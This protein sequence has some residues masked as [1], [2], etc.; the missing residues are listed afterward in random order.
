MK[1]KTTLIEMIGEIDEGFIS[2]YNT[3]RSERKKQKRKN[4]IR[5]A[6]SIAAGAVAMAAIAVAIPFFMK[7]DGNLPPVVTADSTDTSVTDTTSP[8]I[9]PK[10]GERYKNY[11]GTDQGKS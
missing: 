10:E 2:E 5:G 1:S 4:Y 11:I 3:A 7:D 8:N 6:V 9:H